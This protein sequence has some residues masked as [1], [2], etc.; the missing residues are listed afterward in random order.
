MRAGVEHVEDAEAEIDALALG[1]L[2]R[3]REIELEISRGLVEQLALTTGGM[4]K[5]PRRCQ[6][7]GLRGAV[8]ERDARRSEDGI[9]RGILNHDRTQITTGLDHVARGHS[10]FPGR[11][12]LSGDAHRVRPVGDTGFRAAA[13]ERSEERRVGKECRSRWSPYH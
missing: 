2:Q 4:S 8:G 3:A 10:Y 12:V 5:P 1:K 6:R 11:E 13:V 9:T 7:I